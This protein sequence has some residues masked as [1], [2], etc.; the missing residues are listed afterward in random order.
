MTVLCPPKVVHCRGRSTDGTDFVYVGRPSKWGNPYRIGPDGDR[1][2]VI[3]LYRRYL[4][5][6]K[7]LLADLPELTGKRLGCWCYPHPCHAQ[8]LVA[9][10][11][12]LVARQSPPL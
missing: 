10:W 2:M 7:D 4:W 12:A 9:A 11:W 8:V 3:A 6:H 1:M 5:Q